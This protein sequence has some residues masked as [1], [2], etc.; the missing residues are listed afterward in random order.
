MQTWSL[1]GAECPTTTVHSVDTA[2]V[3][4][5]VTINSTAA[6]G[7]TRVATGS[8]KDMRGESSSGPS[9]LDVARLGAAQHVAVTALEG[10]NALQAPVRRRSG[11]GEILCD[12]MDFAQQ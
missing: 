5:S 1:D 9:P 6:K 3:D 12:A 4:V 10:R 7:S 11:P 8:S 2:H